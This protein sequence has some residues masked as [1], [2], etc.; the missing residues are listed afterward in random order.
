MC[1]L[2]D[3]ADEVLEVHE[4]HMHSEPDP[5]QVVDLADRIAA[6][7]RGRTLGRGQDLAMLL[8]LAQLLDPTVPMDEAEIWGVINAARGQPA[9]HDARRGIVLHAPE[10][11]SPWSQVGADQPA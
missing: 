7:A 1:Q 9:Y 4:H 10:G 6:F 8:V 3:L 2:S 11:D 5:S